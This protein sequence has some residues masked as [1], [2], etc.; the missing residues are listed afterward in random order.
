MERREVVDGG[1]ERA[2]GFPEH[3][4]VAG[5][6]EDVEAELA[7]ELGEFELVPEHV[8]DGRA[9]FLRDGDELHLVPDKSEQ[10]QVFLED[11]KIKFVLVRVA[12]EGAEQGEHI[13]GHAGLAALD[14]GRGKADFHCGL[15]SRYASILVWR[16]TLRTASPGF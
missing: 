6:V 11:E 5:D 16:R 4:A 15:S 7:G 9:V 14:D 13:L 3:A 2:M 1:D 12:P 8:F 10:G